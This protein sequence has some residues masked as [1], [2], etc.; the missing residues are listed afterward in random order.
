MKRLILILFVAAVAL[1]GCKTTKIVKD[2]HYVHD[3]TYIHE[4]EY[5]F[6]HDTVIREKHTVVKM[7]D[8]SE[9]AEYGIRI[10]RA[11]QAWLVAS[12][13]LERYLRYLQD[14]STNINHTSHTD[15]SSVTN[16]PEPIYIE[17]ELSWWQKTRIKAAGYL[18][19]LCLI[20]I[21]LIARRP[22]ARA[23]A[24][25]TGV[26]LTLLFPGKEKTR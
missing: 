14:Q 2:T 5:H 7:L 23:V 16:P 10:G 26:N 1:S 3:T 25:L 18:F 13:E 17:K 4:N 19:I 8:S 24:A 22:I 11:E 9:M 6:Q 21:G 12:T 15:S 20:L